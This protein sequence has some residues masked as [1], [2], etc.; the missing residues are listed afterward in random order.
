MCLLQKNKYSRQSIAILNIFTYYEVTIYIYIQYDMVAGPIHITA[1]RLSK[2]D[3]L[4]PFAH[5]KISA[6]IQKPHVRTKIE[7][8]DSHWD[9]QF[10]IGEPFAP[11]TWVT[12]T[13]MLIVVSKS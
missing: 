8:G 7:G 13:A 6:I 5:A 2:V 10:N 12:A 4:H 11:E 1:D 3:F 9:Y